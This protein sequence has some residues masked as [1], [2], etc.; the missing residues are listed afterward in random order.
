VD[1]FFDL[2]KPCWFPECVELRKQ[3]EEALAAA[4]GDNCPSCQRTKI[5]Q[6]FAKLIEAP[7]AKAQQS[8]LR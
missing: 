3:H 7:L 5:R 2:G 4:G 8:Q 1:D 6:K